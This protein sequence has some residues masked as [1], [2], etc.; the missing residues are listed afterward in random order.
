MNEDDLPE[1]VRGLAKEAVAH[2]MMHEKSRMLA[3]SCVEAVIAAEEPILTNV[4]QHVIEGCSALILNNDKFDTRLPDGGQETYMIVISLAELL[5]CMAYMMEHQE[6]IPKNV[7]IDAIS[8]IAKADA[9]KRLKD[10]PAE[11]TA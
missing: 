6:Q 10:A 11:G 2:M 1:E 7:V 5:G 3:Q 8:M 4:I 9:D